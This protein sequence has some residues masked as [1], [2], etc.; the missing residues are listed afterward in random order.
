MIPTFV[1][2]IFS[3]I[4]IFFILSSI[5]HFFQVETETYLIYVTYVIIL[6]LFYAFLP[7]ESGKLFNL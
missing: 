6:T 5:L 4:S 2:I 1:Y 7:V 3:V